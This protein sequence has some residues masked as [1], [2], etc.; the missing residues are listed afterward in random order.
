M[1]SFSQRVINWCIAKIRKEAF[2]VDAH[3]TDYD[4][5]LI[6]LERVKALSRGY[7]RRPM[8]GEC[9]GFLFVGT[10]V[11]VL[12]SR[13][14]FLGRSV[15][16]ENGV[17]INALSTEGV[18]LGD[19]VTIGAYTII[20]CTGSLDTLGRGVK[21]GN[22]SGLGSSSFL[23]AAGGITIGNNVIMGNSVRFHSENHIFSDTDTLIRKQ[24][25]TNKGIVIEDDCWIGAGSTFLDGVVVGKGSV[26]GANSLVNKSIPP[27]AV[28]AG[29]PARVF[30]TRPEAE[31]P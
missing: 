19:N 11:K 30:R 8:L 26:V 2:V 31:T 25:V 13:R 14:V 15:T 12:H 27:F 9:K 29:N 5:L 6:C 23:G 1:S 10:H 4:L 21:I 28:A 22:N 17:E 20:R 7:L 24:G 18:S 16:I 3:M